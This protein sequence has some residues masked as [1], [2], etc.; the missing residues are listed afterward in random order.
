M[1]QAASANSTLTTT[2][3]KLGGDLMVK[4]VSD[5]ARGSSG[6]NEVEKGYLQA[7]YTQVCMGGGRGGLA[8]NPAENCH[9]VR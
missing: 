2:M 8:P 6:A 4:T 3:G 9:G 7:P 5:M 1:L